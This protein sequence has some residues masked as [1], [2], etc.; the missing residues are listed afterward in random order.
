M[1]PDI[2]AQ[3]ARVIDAL[4]DNLHRVYFFDHQGLSDSE[5]DAVAL[6]AIAIAE[7]QTDKATIDAALATVHPQLRD[8]IAA[9]RKSAV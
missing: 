1:G 9:A 5:R 4:C 2:S 3:D 6:K 8:K 7:G